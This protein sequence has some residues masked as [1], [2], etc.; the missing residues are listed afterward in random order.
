MW[1]FSQEL[2]SHSFKSLIFAY[3]D[4]PS[5]SLEEV[6]LGKQSSHLYPLSS[7]TVYHRSLPSRSLR[8]RGLLTLLV[9]FCYLSHTLSSGSR[10]PPSQDHCSHSSRQAFIS[11]NDCSLFAS[12]RSRRTPPL[13]DLLITSVKMLSPMCSEA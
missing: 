3:Q 5:L 8:G 6:V 11:V 13:P 9:L 1:Q 12:I 7:R 2:L 10:F 4:G